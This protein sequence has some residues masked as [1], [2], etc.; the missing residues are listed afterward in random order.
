MFLEIGQFYWGSSM[1]IF[2]WIAAD[3]SKSISSY[4]V[5]DI[6]LFQGDNNNLD[7][8]CFLNK[9]IHNVTKV[10]FISCFKV[11]RKFNSKNCISG[12]QPRYASS[13][14][15]LGMLMDEHIQIFQWEH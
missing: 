13:V 3:Y 10:Y 7:K 8:W 15:D 4:W 12:E 11:N 6:M 5:N 2:L 14:N 9:Q 1:H